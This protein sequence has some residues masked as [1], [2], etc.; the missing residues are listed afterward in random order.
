MQ[1][2]R[3]TSQTVSCV[4]RDRY[5]SF[6]AGRKSVTS[7][8]AIR[9]KAVARVSF[10]VR[11]SPNPEWLAFAVDHELHDGLNSRIVYRLKI[12]IPAVVY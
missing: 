11:S 8:A 10:M 4:A 5:G 9:Y 1:K 6:P 12:A 3:I 7:L 2:W